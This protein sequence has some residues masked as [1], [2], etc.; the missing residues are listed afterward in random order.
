M[1]IVSF[2]V[3]YDEILP[4]IRTSKGLLVVFRLALLTNA[5]LPPFSSEYKTL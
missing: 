3:S 1:F 2:F 4:I 5:I